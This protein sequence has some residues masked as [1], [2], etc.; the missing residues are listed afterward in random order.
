MT[1]IRVD[2]RTEL[3]ELYS[4]TASPALVDVPDLPF[5]MTDG[6]GDPHTA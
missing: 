3:R 4:A 1:A 6:H 2:L 5:L